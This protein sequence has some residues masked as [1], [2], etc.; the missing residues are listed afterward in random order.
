MYTRGVMKSIKIL[1]N[2]FKLI[3]CF[4][5]LIILSGCFID[6]PLVGGESI[7]DSKPNPSIPSS[8]MSTTSTTSTTSIISTTST[9]S[10][11]SMNSPKETTNSFQESF[12]ITSSNKLDILV[13]LPG[14]SDVEKGLLGRNLGRLLGNTYFQSLDWQV[15]FISEDPNQNNRDDHPTF[16]PLKNQSGDIKD[17][18][19]NEPIY[20][21]TPGLEDDHII[22]ELVIETMNS[23]RANKVQPLIS[24]IQSVG[25]T[26]NQEFFREDAFL[27]TIV[28]SKG[29][30]EEEDTPILGLIASVQNHLGDS[31]QF[32]AH[33]L[34]T[35]VGDTDCAQ[36]QTQSV[37]NFSY[38]ISALIDEVGGITSSIC[39]EDEDY[40]SFMTQVESNIKEKLVS[41]S[42]EI[43]LKYTNVVE[44]TISLTFTPKENAQELEFNSQESK[45]IFNTPVLEGTT[46]QVSY[47]YIES[48]DSTESQ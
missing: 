26:E 21:L 7:T 5:C 28:L 11:P 35:K 37:A 31:K 25:K 47:D 22:T 17:S 42:D 38:A 2:S 45:I 48:E 43:K 8:S 36:A 41:N 1:K 39:G 46:I 3:F 19:N 16:L 33:G 20:I 32:V 23:S 4:S 34:I 14:Q 30:D 29:Q 13:V 44:D 27:A 12:S 10:N 24:L 40:G 18:E 6:K 9:T 15:A